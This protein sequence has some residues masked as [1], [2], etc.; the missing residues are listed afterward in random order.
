M[1]TELPQEVARSKKDL[2]RKLDGGGAESG[3][4]SWWEEGSSRKKQNPVGYRDI[5]TLKK[6]SQRT[7]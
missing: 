1:G 2:Q 6:K 5:N 4:S 3:D 7:R